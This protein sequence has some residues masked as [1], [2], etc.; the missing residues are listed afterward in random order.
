M[1]SFLMVK[2]HRKTGLKYLCKTTQNPFKYKG[3]GKYWLLHL[4]RHGEEHDTEIIRE[5]DSTDDLKNW[6]IYYSNLWNVVES[7][8]WAN[9]K[10]ETGDGGS[11]K[12]HL[13]SAS[14]VEKR[15]GDNHPRKKNPEKW[16]DVGNHLK[17]RA[18]GTSMASDR[19]KAGTHNF[20]N[21]TIRPKRDKTRYEFINLN[22][23]II[24]QMT[25]HEFMTV[26]ELG[27][28]GVCELLTG[29]RKTIK[30]WALMPRHGGKLPA[31]MIRE[32]TKTLTFSDGIN[33][34][35]MPVNAF[36]KKYSLP[37][38]ALSQLI[39]GKK[40]VVNGWRLSQC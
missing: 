27:D 18:D 32:N 40:K 3:S 31:L 36:M 4:K 6:G 12:G 35:S 7:T 33:I 39:S 21:Y 19:V 25:R 5:C 10:P 14:S 23:K 29:K 30:G 2:T 34:V 22:T 11:L 28:E 9:L 15:S 16:E 13:K 20:L 24:H 37:S 26:T 38:G 17:K 8:E 1:P